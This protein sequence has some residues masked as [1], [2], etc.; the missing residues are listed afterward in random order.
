MKKAVKADSDT[1]FACFLGI[2]QGSVSGAKAQKKIPPAWFFQVA[3]KTGLS[4]DFLYSGKVTPDPNRIAEP[5]EGPISKIQAGIEI[6]GREDLVAVPLVEARLSAGRGNVQVS[7]AAEKSFVFPYSFLH[8]KG[9]ISE[10]V[11]MKAEGDS[12]QPEILDGDSVLIDQS[13]TDIR[14]GRIFA[15]GFEGQIYLK[16]IDKLPGKIIFK[17][18]NPVY[19]PVIIDLGEQMI[20]QFRMIGQVLW[21]GREY[22]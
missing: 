2:S 5:P 13:K 4:V 17:S 18:V 6:S 11:V 10:M 3:D 1:A 21:V 16:R 19:E 14:L 15:V 7:G 22:K 12:M 9:N 8:R 20:D